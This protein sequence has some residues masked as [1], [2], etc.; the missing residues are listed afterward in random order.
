[1]TLVRTSFEIGGIDVSVGGRTASLAPG[2]AQSAQLSW[3]GNDPA[4]GT[5]VTFKSGL[6]N[7]RPSAIVIDGPWSLFRLLDRSVLQTA[8]ATRDRLSVRI[9]SGLAEADLVL[10]ES[11]LANPFGANPVSAFR[12]PRAL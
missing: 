5:S 10:Q 6:P 2:S 8:A 12:C 3:P 7:S 9:A 1:M 11:S 4:A